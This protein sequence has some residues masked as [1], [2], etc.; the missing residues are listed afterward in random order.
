MPW[1]TATKNDS[2]P[3]Q[4]P[5]A[6]G[7]RRDRLRTVV[8]YEAARQTASSRPTAGHTYCTVLYVRRLLRLT[9]SA[10]ATATFYPLH[11]APYIWECVFPSATST[12]SNHVSAYAWRAPVA[13][14]S[15]CLVV[16][17][18]HVAATSATCGGL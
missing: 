14:L 12:E 18:L 9:A 2:K 16:W 8:L 10:H 11:G 4:A 3:W 1:F 17:P 13:C 6:S 5:L 7:S 15:P